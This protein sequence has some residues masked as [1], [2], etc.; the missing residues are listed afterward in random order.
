MLR[1]TFLA[2]TATVAL[3]SG[4]A[5][6]QSDAPTMNIWDTLV[7]TDGFS[8]LTS[9][10]QETG[11]DLALQGPGPFTL[12]APDD[13]AFGAFQTE[14]EEKAAMLMAP[15]N[16][17]MFKNVLNY[18]VVPGNYT[19]QDFQGKT[20]EMETLN[21]QMI[22]IDGLDTMRMGNGSLIR[23]ISATNGTIFV[24]DTVQMPPM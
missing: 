17:E 13:D 15:E 21:G 19:A 22:K 2:V 24:I 14:N 4:T 10:M 16:M 20:L 7:A 18:H 3:M 23:T 11:L 5:Q 1:R 12:F 9:A 8:D 6:A